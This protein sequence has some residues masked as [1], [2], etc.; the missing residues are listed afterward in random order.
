MLFEVGFLER[1]ENHCQGGGIKQGQITEV[2]SHC[3]Q[4]DGMVEG[5][6]GGRG[7]EGKRRWWLFLFLYLP[8][9]DGAGEAVV[10][11]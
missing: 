3:E 11:L 10:N 9:G 5:G 1:N 7:E 4:A 8:G 6:G 2:F